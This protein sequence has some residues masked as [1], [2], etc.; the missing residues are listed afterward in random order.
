MFPIV[1]LGVAIVLVLFGGKK[2]T[3]PPP[4]PPDTSTQGGNPYHTGN[5]TGVQGPPVPPPP[6]APHVA[7]SA[8]V[9]PTETATSDPAL[10]PQTAPFRE[11]S[12]PGGA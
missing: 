4:P 12:A 5:P 10:T 7:P 3:A 6:A 8:G 2:G 11:P 9:V 1:L